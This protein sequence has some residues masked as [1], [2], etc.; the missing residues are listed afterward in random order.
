MI[1]LALLLLKLHYSIRFAKEIKFNQ[2]YK[3]GIERFKKER[4][5]YSLI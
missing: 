4:F 5:K 3:W 1:S 2:S